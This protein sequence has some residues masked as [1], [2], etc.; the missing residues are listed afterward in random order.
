[1]RRL[2]GGKIVGLVI[3]M[4]TAYLVVK[5]FAWK[6]FTFMTGSYPEISVPPHCSVSATP[7]V[8][9]FKIPAAAVLDEEGK[10]PLFDVDYFFLWLECRI[11]DPSK[12]E[13]ILERLITR[14]EAGAWR[15]VVI[16]AD[17]RETLKR[18]MDGEIEVLTAMERSGSTQRE[19]LKAYVA[20]L[21]RDGRVYLHIEGRRW[22]R[23][24]TEKEGRKEKPSA[25]AGITPWHRDR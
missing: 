20:V 13:Q 6:R 8:N 17:E 2:S 16:G 23:R 4:L 11:R 21:R 19:G 24:T 5:T 14:M 25:P 7:L 12:A 3:L 9:I 15:E 22:N 18:R 1:M 10:K